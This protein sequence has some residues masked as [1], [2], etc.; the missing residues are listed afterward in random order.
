[1]NTQ[2][3]LF[4][5]NEPYSGHA[6]YVRTDTS[7]AAAKRQESKSAK[8]RAK[9]LAFLEFMPATDEE[10]QRMLPM[11]PNTERPRRREL[12]L[13]GKIMDSGKRHKGASGEDAI[14]WKVK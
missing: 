3:D 5:G 1:M 10:L 2:E 8:D 7:I 12:A 13:S 6:P 4:T 9:I 11:E 14:V